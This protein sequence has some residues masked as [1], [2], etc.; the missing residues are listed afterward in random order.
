MNYYH[1]LLMNI[2]GT[3]L[4]HKGTT[5][6]EYIISDVDLKSER[7]T[8]IQLDT[9]SKVQYDLEVFIC[10][11]SKSYFYLNDEDDALYHIELYDQLLGESNA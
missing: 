11:F 3:L 9:K 7:V 10:I 5:I 8:I 2:R 6:Y 4:T 1:T